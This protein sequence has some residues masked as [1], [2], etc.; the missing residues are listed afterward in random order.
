LIG[1]KVAGIDEL[2]FTEEE[3][4][5]MVKRFFSG[6]GRRVSN[7]MRWGTLSAFALLIA[8]IALIWVL[9]FRDQKKQLIRQTQETLVSI[10]RFKGQEIENWR[11]E[12]MADAWT[13]FRTPILAVSIGNWMEGPDQEK[14]KAL[15]MGRLQASKSSNA[16]ENVML[17]DRNGTI[18]LSTDEHLKQIS[19][20]TRVQLNRAFASQTVYFGDFYFCRQCNRIHLDLIVP[21]LADKEGR[22]EPVAA[23]LFRIDPNAFLFPMIR[24][25]PTPSATSEAFLVRRENDHVKFLTPLRHRDNPDLHFRVIL[26][27]FQLPAARAVKGEEGIIRGIDYRGAEVLTSVKPIAGSTWHLICK[28]DIHETIAPLQTRMFF[29]SFAALAFLCVL[30]SI[31]ILGANVQQ[32]QYYKSLYSKEIEHQAMSKHFEYLVRFANDIIILAD[33]DLRITEVNSRGITLFGYSHR[34]LLRLKLPDLIGSEITKSETKEELSGDKGK[35]WEADCRKKDGASFAGEIS[36]RR[37]EI[38]GTTFTQAIIRDISERREARNAIEEKTAYLNQLFNN[39]PLAAQL[40]DS[41]GRIL[42]I[43]PATSKLFGYSVKEMAGHLLDELIVPDGRK[44]E[45]KNY[46]ERSSRGETLLFENRRKRKDGTEFDVQCIAFPVYFED[47]LI[48]AYTIYQDIT[49]SREAAAEIAQNL[50]KLQKAMM[51]TIEALARV[52]E[53]RDPYTADHQ[54]RVS[55]LA[56]AIA[57]ELGMHPDRIEGLRVAAIVHDIGKLS[58]PAEILSKPSKLTDA[59]FNLIREH[60][61]SGFE[62]LKDIKFPWPVARIVHEHHERF[63]GS[64]YPQ[65]LNGEYVLLESKILA[66]ADVVEAISSHRPYRPSRGLDVAMDEITSNMGILYDETVCK[67]CL[68]LF[69]EKRF[70]FTVR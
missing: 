35:I 58:V 34:E 14:G 18:R 46:T 41:K 19:S 17:L 48:G 37:I 39:I 38:A 57:S 2:T 61:R 42:Q 7:W 28:T 36:A 4:G 64:G 40:C 6:V 53:N 25:W 22:K 13:V 30:V 67:A 33:S 50:L 56:C 60:P 45:A 69:K 9:T 31:L 55:D 59:E 70:N 52:V 66:V 54:R 49:A 65:K 11:N 10:A 51:E 62:I 8:L 5:N 29:V 44:E 12:R 3:K 21:L 68:K 47:R 1:S 24:T 32:K 26:T 23:M 63:N 15:I 20:E 16:Y 43:N 27:N